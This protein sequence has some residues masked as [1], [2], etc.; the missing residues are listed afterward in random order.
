M[1][2]KKR[3]CWVA[4]REWL[5]KRLLIVLRKYKTLQIYPWCRLLRVPD[6]HSKIETNFIR[7]NIFVAIC[8]SRDL[9]LLN[10]EY[11]L[12]IK[13]T[14][15]R[16]ILDGEKLGYNFWSSSEFGGMHVV[17]LWS[18]L[19]YF[20]YK[21][22]SWKIGFDPPWNFSDWIKSEI[23]NILSLSVLVKSYD[24]KIF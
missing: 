11:I 3:D 4:I 2:S 22:S 13:M 8:G 10:F 7:E 20:C 19:I 5:L 6:R 14:E 16:L 1:L 21:W 23:S 17:P 15:K 24:Q 18:F 12:T 9:N